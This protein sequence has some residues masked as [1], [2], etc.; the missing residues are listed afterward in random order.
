MSRYLSALGIL[1]AARGA[2]EKG[3]RLNSFPRRR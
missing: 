3:H 1:R 2:D